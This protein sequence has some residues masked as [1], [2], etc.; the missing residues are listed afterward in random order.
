VFFEDESAEAVVE[1][2]D[3]ETGREVIA[4]LLDAGGAPGLAGSTS[5]RGFDGDRAL[6]VTLVVNTTLTPSA[7]TVVL[8]LTVPRRRILDLGV[9]V[10][11]LRLHVLDEESADAEWLPV[12]LDARPN[13]PPS[14][15]VGA[16]GFLINNDD[17][18]TYWAV[19]D[20]LSTFALGATAPAG[21]DDGPVP[22]QP[23]PAV[24]ACGVSP[25][26]TLGLAGWGLMLC[27]LTPLRRRNARR[28][29]IEAYGS[30]G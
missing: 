25:C 24:P 6:P 30:S 10:G 29:E 27:A 4:Q 18:V 28:P 7:F 5:F 11:D 2:I 1:I 16:F 13:A 26:G 19:R 9:A 23:A 3:G 21:D 8:E 17:T 15:N 22:E 12:G 14:R 20:R